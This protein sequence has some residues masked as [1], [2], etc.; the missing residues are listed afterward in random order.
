MSFRYIRIRKKMRHTAEAQEILD[1]LERYIAD[2]EDTPIRMLMSHWRDQED[3]VSYGEIIEAILH[4]EDGEEFMN[5]WVNDYTKFV[6]DKLAK[7]WNAATIAGSKGQPV[8]D[9]IQEM[10]TFDM[11]D[12]RMEEWISQRSGSFITSVTEQQQEAV[13]NLLRQS[14]YEKYSPD[15]LAKLIRSCIGLT[16][17]Q[18]RAVLR[19]YD[20]MKSSMREQHPRM[21]RSN[22]EE[23]CRRKALSYAGRLH[24]DRAETIARTE[25]AFAYNHGMHESIRQAVQQGLM[26]TVEKRWVTSSNDNV[27]PECEALNGKQIG[28]ND[29]FE[30]GKHTHLFDGQEACPPL[31]PRCCC[32]VEYIEV[33]PP[34]YE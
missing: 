27:C 22:L 13:R 9:K 3:A 33:A 26:G 24:R 29:E 28:F 8:M 7:V 34:K 30:F 17:G 4:G 14:I 15:E 25:M 1:R 32:V 2:N 19:F 16:D 21:L 18:S 5:E 20:T 12:S 31:H 23:R 11:N 10:L 6:N